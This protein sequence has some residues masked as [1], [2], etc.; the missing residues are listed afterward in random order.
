MLVIAR[1][2]SRWVR[3][4]FSL[5]VLLIV[6]GWVGGAQAVYTTKIVDGGGQPQPGARPSCARPG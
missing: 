6:F 2:K 4:R 1:G 5:L 3:A